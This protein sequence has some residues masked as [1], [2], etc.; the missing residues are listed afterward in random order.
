ML[1]FILSFTA[2]YIQRH[3]AEGGGG[4]GAHAIH[5]SRKKGS[6]LRPPHVRDLVKE[7]SFFVPRYEVWGGGGGGGG[8]GVNNNPRGISGYDAS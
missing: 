2:H 1:V 5:I 4:G 8:G 3:G 7:G 6:F